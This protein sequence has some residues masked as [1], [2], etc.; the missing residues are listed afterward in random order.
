M[1]GWGEAFREKKKR[2]VEFSMRVRRIRR[3]WYHF[4][5]DTASKIAGF[6]CLLMALGVCIGVWYALNGA[7]GLF[8]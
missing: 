6:V 1:S 2:D 5:E 4:T 3:T 8:R 7:L